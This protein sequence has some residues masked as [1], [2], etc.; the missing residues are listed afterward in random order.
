MGER[1]GKILLL[2]HETE[3]ANTIADKLAG[4]GF[5]VEIVSEVD[6]SLEGDIDDDVDVV[7]CDI[8][9]PGISWDAVFE[10]LSERQLDIAAIM[11]SSHRDVV[12]VMTAL[13]LGF[14]DFF[15]KPIDDWEALYAS[16]SSICCLVWRSLI[17]VPP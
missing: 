1:S 5:Y 16:Q 8:G 7:L 17:T 4:R 13:R 3:T 12:D 10:I 9:M 14:S 15:P 2:E 11:L 6:P